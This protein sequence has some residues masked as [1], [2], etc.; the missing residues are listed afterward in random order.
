MLGM[1]WGQIVVIVLVGVF[2]LGPERIPDAVSGAVA[3]L[4][5]LQALA[6][7][8]RT[9]MLGTVGPEI[10]DLRS[11][12]AELQALVGVQELRSLRELHPQRL[13]NQ[14][15]LGDGVAD[16]PAKVSDSSPIGSNTSPTVTAGRS[17]G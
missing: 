17:V 15:I 8:S 13:I 5:R 11:Q 10:A 1:S 3:A 9:D 6:G 14:I 2:I 16:H 12:L 7:N 4:R